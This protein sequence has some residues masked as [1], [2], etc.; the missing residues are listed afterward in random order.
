MADAFG[1]AAAVV[2]RTFG[3]L[4]RVAATHPFGA[5]TSKTH[6]SFLG[7]EPSRGDVRRLEQLELAPDRYLV[8]GRDV[9]LHYPGGVQGSRLTGA[10]LERHLGV[11]G[12]I[13]NWKTVTR[14]AEMARDTAAG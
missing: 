14:L 10:L 5:D 4:D 1:V 13:R 9:F 8:A 3:E 2:L 12:T 11:P 7:R 6:V